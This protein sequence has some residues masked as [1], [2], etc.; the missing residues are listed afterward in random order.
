VLKDARACDGWCVQ[1]CVVLGADGCGG[2]GC[3]CVWW[4]GADV[5]DGWW[6]QVHGTTG[7]CRCV[8]VVNG[9]CM[10]EWWMVREGVGGDWKMQV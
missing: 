9:G 2:C 3:T 4:V 5:C 10:W 1:L 8:C 6:V 7:G